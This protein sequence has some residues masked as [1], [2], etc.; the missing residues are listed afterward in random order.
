M[1]LP[2]EIAVQVLTAEAQARDAG[3]GLALHA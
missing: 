3:T 2:R 1:L